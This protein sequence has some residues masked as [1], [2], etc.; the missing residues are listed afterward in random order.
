M[1]QGDPNE[2][3][4]IERLMALAPEVLEQALE[5][6][7]K[8][9]ATRAA[10]IREL[11]HREGYG[12]DAVANNP[13]L[14]ATLATIRSARDDSPGVE[15][16][17]TMLSALP[18][19]ALAETVADANEFR[20]SVASKTAAADDVTIATTSDAHVPAS[21]D[22]NGVVLGNKY[23]IVRLLGRGGF[24]SVY[25]G[26]DEMLGAS[27][28]IK[29]LNVDMLEHPAAIGQFLGEARLLTTLDH[30][31]IVR[32]ITFDKT[33][34][35]MHYFV[36]EFLRGQ[37]L[38]DVLTDEGKLPPADVIK[39]L[40]QILSALVAAHNLPDGRSL[41]HLDLKPRNVFAVHGDDR[42]IKVIDFGISQHVGA[43]ARTV[44]AAVA[45]SDANAAVAD[46][47]A[48]MS[49]VHS[50]GA[51]G[52]T[53]K[54]VQRALGGTPLYASPEHCRHL[55]G[56]HDIVE[57]DGRSD[58]YSLGIMGFEML[59]G[60]LPWNPKTIRECFQTAIE[61]PLPS[62]SSVGAKVPSNL[63]RFLQKCTA[64]VR[65]DRFADVRSALEEL[66]RIANPKR[67]VLAIVAGVLMVAAL[68]VWQLWPDTPVPKVQLSQQ[69]VFVGPGPEHRTA[70]IEVRNLLA[71]SRGGAL[72]WV[73]DTTEQRQQLLADWQ[74]E[75]QGGTGT[76]TVLLT[77][78]ENCALVDEAIVYLEIGADTPQFSDAIRI[79]Y[80]PQGACQIATPQIPGAGNRAV[81]PQG[82]QIEAVLSGGKPDW[83]QRV[84]VRFGGQLRPTTFYD[85]QG[86]A[87]YR[88]ALDEFQ[89]LF[90][91]QAAPSTPST[92]AM[93]VTDKAGN[94]YTSEHSVLL[95]TS[96]LTIAPQLLECGTSAA[97]PLVY[98]GTRPLLRMHA[99]RPV[100]AK[101]TA[102]TDEGATI[103]VLAERV[104]EGDYRL[105]INGPATAYKADLF[106][107]VEEDNRVFHAI[108]ARRT[109]SHTMRFRYEVDR[110]ALLIS[111][112]VGDTLGDGSKVVTR[113]DRVGFRLRRDNEV[114][115][116]VRVQCRLGDELQ[117]EQLL[118][119]HRDKERVLAPIPL[120]QD[121]SYTVTFAT[122]QHFA[123]S[124]AAK[125]DAPDSMPT[126]AVVRDT[127]APLVTVVQ[128]PP[129][130]ITPDAGK[131]ASVRIEGSDAATKLVC[132]LS[133]PE[134]H[135]VEIPLPVIAVA[136]E[137]LSFAQFGTQPAQLPD[138]SYRLKVSAIDEAGNVGKAEDVS[139]VVANQGPALRLISPSN[140]NRWD[141]VG[142]TFTIKVQAV[143]QNGVEQV[144]CRLTTA[145]GESTD[146]FA[147]ALGA[148]ADP[149]SAEWRT[150]RILPSK[151]SDQPVTIQWYGKDTYGN[152]KVEQVETVN[153]ALPT[154]EAQLRAIVWNTPPAGEPIPMRLVRGNADF[155]YGGRSRGSEKAAF[156]KVGLALDDLGLR[157]LPSQE[158]VA[159]FYLDENEVTVALYLDFLRDENGYQK[160][161]H[162]RNARPDANRRRQLI[163]D[164][165]NQD[166]R[167][168]VTGLDW[169]E[170][171]AYATWAGKRLPTAIE[172]EYAVR[173][174]LEYRVVSCA[175][176]GFA[177]NRLAVGVAAPWPIE[178]GCDRVA[179]RTGEGIR[180]LCSNVSEWV[181]DKDGRRYHAGASF[182]DGDYH[183]SMLR[184]ADAS[185]R[186]GHVGFRCAIDT[187]LVRNQLET[188]DS[189]QF[190]IDATNSSPE[191]NR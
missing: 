94:I 16:A 79:V 8:S 117:H 177:R 181:S 120:L 22:L 98:P 180:N 130:R 158:D 14:Q 160:A 168:P 80:L 183:F 87:T 18:E 166:R 113:D 126:I 171:S 32:W 29:V 178:E 121:G 84:D 140:N 47:R 165:A 93:I 138:G 67:P 55:R 13:Q 186:P 176:P 182:Q 81:D 86:A 144:Q 114:E 17:L 40:Q 131:L 48:T 95:A 83:V 6:L 21:D 152:P 49:T 36:M 10:R 174:G 62:L 70:A 169:Y 64:K 7:T 157:F 147:M 24:G 78:P 164:L 54:G 149:R 69:E 43:A 134:E 99:S 61:S 101:L 65:E 71:A 145:K 161:E 50:D 142:D 154:F 3:K 172:W 46:L 73:N 108:E 91:A 34:E 128:A 125:N 184:S 75:L 155:T 159:N 76:P 129:E 175:G 124:N 136:E 44:P 39:I 139:F 133:G 116:T 66:E 153:K 104:T 63:E 148:G 119:L 89:E 123:G 150:S 19:V 141:N 42:Q 20:A 179:G 37:E 190:S 102:R 59:S 31:N 96:E 146:W 132:Q 107:T 2:R 100:D 53:P 105:T 151:W 88:L 92:F 11:L 4:H 60:R 173:G 167:I 127:Q 112:G 58:L 56:D 143:D 191:R 137:E 156:G 27:V 45:A 187:S 15:E 170:C 41:L 38:S 109:A 90:V 35:G 85:A 188:G 110:P 52:L 72:R 111:K 162:W 68:L 12:T 97:D 33:P 163:A 26:I 9:D 118:E 1:S 115:L 135:S 185:A 189:T 122:Y 30:A 51:K 74:L 57:L 25:Q 23:R 28:A 103:E 82:A 106:V 5:A 77:P